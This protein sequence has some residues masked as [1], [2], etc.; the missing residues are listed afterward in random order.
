MRLLI[1]AT[2][3]L[4]VAASTIASAQPRDLGEEVSLVNLIATPERYHGKV[5][6][7]TVY[8]TI[9]F[10]NMSLCASRQVLTNKDCLWLHIDSGP[11]ETDQ[12]LKRYLEREKL[13]KQFHRQVISL[14]GTFNQKNTGHLGGWS[15]SIEKVT[16]VYGERLDVDFTSN[17]PLQRARR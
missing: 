2:T 9:G 14:R 6:S 4:C 7:V 8:A 5:V 13:W 11:F 17:P 15:G 1:S 3:A 16:E 10:E 12:D